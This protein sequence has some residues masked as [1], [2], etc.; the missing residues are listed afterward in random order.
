MR[1]VAGGRPLQTVMRVTARR[2]ER[3][4]TIR[5]AVFDELGQVILREMERGGL[6][7]LTV[8]PVKDDDIVWSKGYGLADHDVPAILP[9]RDAET[10]D[11]VS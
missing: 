9:S 3:S 5:A 6:P 4:V 11:S 2:R 1:G 8:A 10:K 7:G